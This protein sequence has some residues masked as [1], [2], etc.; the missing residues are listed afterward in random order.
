MNM[1]LKNKHAIRL[2]PIFLLLLILLCGCDPSFEKIPPDYPNS[3]WVCE[4]PHIEIVVGEHDRYTAAFI[5]DDGEERRFALDFL[6][7]DR[8][9]AYVNSQVVFSEETRLFRG[10]YKGTKDEFTIILQDGKLWDDGYARLV[11]KRVE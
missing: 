2:I 8:V 11:F 1:I 7:G 9:G 10:Y 4:D 6:Y 3:R 5:E